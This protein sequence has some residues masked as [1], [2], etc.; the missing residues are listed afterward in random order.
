MIVYN[1]RSQQ[2]KHWHTDDAVV[3]FTVLVCVAATHSRSGWRGWRD[4]TADRSHKRSKR[5]DCGTDKD[6]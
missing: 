6:G 2:D 5:D 3:I 4:H 1:E